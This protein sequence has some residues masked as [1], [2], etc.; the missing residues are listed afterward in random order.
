MNKC[1]CGKNLTYYQCCSLYI[2]Q[3]Q[4]PA[5]PEILMRSRYT[6]YTKAN[7]A[8]IIATMKGKPLIDFDPAEASLWAQ[9]VKWRQLKIISS[10]P[11]K[12]T[13]DEGW[14][15]FKAVFNEKG[16]NQVI[17]ECSKFQRIKGQ[18]FYVGGDYLSLPE[19]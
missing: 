4:R 13:E 9:S 12:T 17:H 14:V 18:W 19:R 6:A 3:K 15:E 8:Y 11:E 2:D 10:F 1:P 7:I 16:K 5:S